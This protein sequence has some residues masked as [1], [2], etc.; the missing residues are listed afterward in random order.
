MASPF[1]HLHNHSQFSLLDGAQKIDD[2]VDKAS[3]FGMKS[4]AITDHGNLFG[5]IKFYKKALKKGIR[6]VLGVEAYVA[7]GDRRERQS[8]PAQKKPYYHLGRRAEK[9]NGSQNLIRVA[10]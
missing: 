10:S 7:F 3:S 1:V 9:C 2:M 6:P 5:A 8:V 4:V